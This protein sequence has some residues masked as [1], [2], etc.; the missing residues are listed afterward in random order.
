M[1][2]GQNDNA[3]LKIFADEEL[4]KEN[5]ALAADNKRLRS[6]FENLE[7]PWLSKNIIDMAYAEKHRMQ[8]EQLR[9]ENDRLLKA[10]DEM[11]HWIV[12]E[13]YDL[14][15]VDDWNAAKEGR[16]AK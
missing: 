11:K 3:L 5:A 15:C 7:S 9:A 4:R 8:V 16:H 6:L 1:S 10:G 14:L 2:L 12:S 13:G